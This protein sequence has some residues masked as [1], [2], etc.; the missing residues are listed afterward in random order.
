MTTVVNNPGGT[1]TANSGMGFLMGIILLLAV[2]F[3]FFYFGLPAIRG[4]TR[5]PQINVPGQID[6]N[7]DTPANGGQ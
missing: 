2:L 4:A 7:V 3:L 5:A 1:D 6:V